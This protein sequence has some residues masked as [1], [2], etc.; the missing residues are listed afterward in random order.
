VLSPVRLMTWTHTVTGGPWPERIGR[1]CR[2]V[3]P[4]R[5]AWAAT[6]PWHGRA[7]YETIVLVEDDPLNGPGTLYDQRDWSCAIPLAFITPIDR[8]TSEL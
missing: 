8:T 1:R 4:G 2:I 3:P 6:Y 5:P 7:A